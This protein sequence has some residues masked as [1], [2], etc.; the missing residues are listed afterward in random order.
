MEILDDLKMFS[1]LIDLIEQ[2]DMYVEKEDTIISLK[3]K[4]FDETMYFISISVSDP[5][6]RKDIIKKINNTILNSKILNDIDCRYKYYLNYNFGEDPT[7]NLVISEVRA[8]SVTDNNMERFYD[9]YKKLIKLR[10]KIEK[11]K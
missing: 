10:N 9:Y 1:E 5:K 2:E 3:K 11:I 7:D 6:K 8:W 4:D